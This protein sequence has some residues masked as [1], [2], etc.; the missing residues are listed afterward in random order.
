MQKKRIRQNINKKVRDWIKSLNNPAILQEIIKIKVEE[1]KDYGDSFNFP[2]DLDAHFPNKEDRDKILYFWNSIYNNVLVSGGCIASMILGEEVNDY[3]IYFMDRNVAFK[4]ASYY[5]RD[6]IARGKLEETSKVPSCLIRDNSTGGVDILIKSM[7]VVGENTKATIS[8]DYFEGNGTTDD[9]DDIIEDFLKGYKA[10]TK[11]SKDKY[12]VQFM[13]S[14]AITLRDDIQL[15]FRFCG[16]SEEIHK[17]FDFAHCMNYW[18]VEEGLVYKQE[19]LVALLER[20]LYYHGS[21]FPL[22]A[23]F[24]IRKFLSRGFHIS[25]G[26]IVK[27]SY[28]I[29][30]LDLDSPKVLQDQLLGCDYAYFSQ[31][32]NILKNRK[33]GVDRT[34]L[35]QLLDQAFGDGDSNE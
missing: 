20:R 21:L 26:E 11:S 18:T 6:M 13:T 2:S 35:F 12:I 4:V 24:R 5:L 27:M 1:P 23:M 30:K 10:E 25:A 32:V 14:N 8:Y 28:D 15:I 3:D 16:N 29:S 9:A 22:A 7:G 31:V 34:Y 17:N 33:E 19:A